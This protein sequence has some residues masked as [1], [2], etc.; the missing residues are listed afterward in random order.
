MKLTASNIAIIA[1]GLVGLIVVYS[2]RAPSN[3]SDAFGAMARGQQ[4]FLREPVY[5]IG[6]LIFGALTAWGAMRVFR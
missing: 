1:V 3:F 5:Y 2:L 6:L 4:F